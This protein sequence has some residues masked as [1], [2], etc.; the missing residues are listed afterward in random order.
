[1]L[2]AAAATTRVAWPK[3]KGEQEG[4]AEGLEPGDAKA[5]A[6]GEPPIEGYITPENTHTHEF[7]RDPKTHTHTNFR[8]TPTTRTTELQR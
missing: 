5:G 3:N 7:Q 2:L 8:G 4:L 6:H 1:M